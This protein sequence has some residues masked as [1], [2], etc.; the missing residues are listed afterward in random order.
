MGITGVLKRS[1][2][3]LA[4]VD[5]RRPTGGEESGCRQRRTSAKIRRSSS[6]RLPRGKPRWSVTLH[7]RN[8]IWKN[9]GVTTTYCSMTEGQ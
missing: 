2:W 8:R 1:T 3:K 4:L 7:P 9:P 5:R 6:Y